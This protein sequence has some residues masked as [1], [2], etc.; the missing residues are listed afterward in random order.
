MPALKHSWQQGHRVL[1]DTGCTLS[2]DH[3]SCQDVRQGPPRAGRAKDAMEAEGELSPLQQF[4]ETEAR[5]L[6]GA[7]F[8]A[9]VQDLFNS[10]E[11]LV[12]SAPL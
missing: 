6:T 5:D 2:Q 1:R 4:V 9:F 3:P 7:S 10:I 11:H 12:T 8:S